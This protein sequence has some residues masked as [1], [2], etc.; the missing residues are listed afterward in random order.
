MNPPSPLYITHSQNIAQP[1][2]WSSDR[3]FFFCSYNNLFSD[4][5]YSNEPSSVHLT[6]PELI[7]LVTVLLAEA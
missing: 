7:W 5:Q 4:E 2:A 6:S 3:L 1:P